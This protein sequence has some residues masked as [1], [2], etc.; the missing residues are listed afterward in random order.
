[1]KF[2]LKGL[3]G[4]VNLLITEL[5]EIASYNQKRLIYRKFYKICGAKNK[6]IHRNQDLNHRSIKIRQFP[7]IIQ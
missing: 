1:M 4:T 6:K 2:K 3:I 7:W 5:D